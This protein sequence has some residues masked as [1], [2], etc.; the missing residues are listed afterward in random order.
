MKLDVLVRDLRIAVR[1]LVRHRGF[2]VAALATLALGI[3]ANTAVFTVIRHV[4]LAPL[5][6]QEPDRAAVIWSQWRGFDKTWVSDAELIDYQTR[7]GAFEEV[8]GWSVLQVNLTGDGDP[9]RIGAALVTPN[10]FSTLGVRPFLGRGFT[11]AEADQVPSTVVV[12]SYELWQTRFGGA[13]VIGRPVQVNG[14]TREIVGIM[15]KGFQLPTD[16]VIDVEEPTRLW[17]PLR[18]NA[19]NRG[20]HG[21]YA[22]ARLKPGATLTQAN[23]ELASLTRQLTADGLY[24]EA[25]RFTAFAVSTT[26]EAVAAVRPALWL[27]FGAVACLLLVACANVANLLLVRGEGR[28]REMAVRCA[29]GAV[30]WRLVRQLIGEA[31]ILAAAAAVCGIALAWVA[32]RLLIT[33]GAAVL[34]R[35]GTIALDWRVIGFAVLVS[36]VTLLLFALVPAWRA[37]RVDLVE[38]L[39]DGSQNAS[40]GARRQRLRGALVVAEV[41]LAL[42]LVTGAGLMLRSLWNLQRIDLGFDPDRVLTLRLA[43]PASQYDTPERVIAFYDRLLADVRALPGVERAGLIRLLPLATDRRLGA[44]DRGLHPSAGGQHAWRLADRHRRRTRGARRTVDR[45]PVDHRGGSRR[46]ARRRARES[47]DGGEVLA[48]RESARPAVPPGRPRSP[49]DHR[50]RHRRQRAP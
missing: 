12:L 46:R 3:G 14:I 40:A 47:V 39:K 2:T 4:L 48:R 33:S 31:A 10:L 38:T 5:P 26:D 15:P 19:A 43:L 18:L 23:A 41:A 11:G 6:Y 42:V 28:A 49:L 21:Y 34:P 9:I 22:A 1:G 36:A 45:R 30:R 8:G 32:L 13:D 37:A 7:I 44:D 50:R 27:V 25:M 20:S 17:A 24:P 29:L 35:A 16:Y